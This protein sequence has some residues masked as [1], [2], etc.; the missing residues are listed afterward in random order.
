M[1]CDDNISS[2]NALPDAAGFAYSVNGVHQHSSDPVIDGRQVLNESGHTPADEHVLIKLRALGTTSVGLDEKVDLREAGDEAFRAFRDDRIY[3]F[4]L[5]AR[6]YEWGAP[7][8][9]EA[10]LRA[11]VELPLNQV[12]VLEQVE[13]PDAVID[14][15]SDINLAARGTERL[16]I[17]H[18][19]TVIVTVNNKPVTLAR[20]WHR[21]AQIKHAA[22]EQGVAIEPDFTLDQEQ[23]DGTATIVGNDDRVFIKGGE[24]FSAVDDHDDS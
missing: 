7:V 13:V 6:G 21:G 10:E 11:L 18:R 23:P 17:A 12:F 14:D 15:D 8:F 24:V 5:E 20:G 2:V 16:A 19:R 3:L 4:T 22:I 1:A 9:N